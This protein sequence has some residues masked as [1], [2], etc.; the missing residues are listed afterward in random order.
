M[1]WLQMIG[2]YRVTM[3]VRVHFVRYQFIYVALSSLVQAITLGIYISLVSTSIQE[4]K[5]FLQSLQALGNWNALLLL[6]I[7]MVVFNIWIIHA[8]R[9]IQAYDKTRIINQI[10]EIS[11][12][13]LVY[14]N[15]NN[16][17]HIR[18]IVTVCNYKKKTRKTTYSYNITASPERTAEYAIDFGVTGKA[19]Q[20]KVAVAEGLPT[21]HI[22]TYE[23]K[24]KALVEPTLKCILAAPIFSKNDPDY[25]VGVLA[26]DSCDDLSTTRFNS[27]E[28]K[29]IAQS[30]ADILSH[31]M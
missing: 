30:W 12:R 13:T 19:I 29:V 15:F 20:L 24:H 27:N 18:A 23:E 21:N 11:S 6:A 25:V 7:G 3:G 28:S 4:K 17:K 10:L 8:S 9:S 5:G 16:K 2:C 26:F 1:L 31:L 22:E 14:P